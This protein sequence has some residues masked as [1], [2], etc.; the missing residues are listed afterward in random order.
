M[1]INRSFLRYLTERKKGWTMFSFIAVIIYAIDWL[2][3]ERQKKKEIY[4]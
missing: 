2:L 4:I 3:Q 1:K